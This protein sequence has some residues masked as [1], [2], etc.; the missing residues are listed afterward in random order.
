MKRLLLVAALAASC[1]AC[2][3]SKLVTNVR[4]YFDDSYTTFSN[5]SS[6][7]Y[8]LFGVTAAG[9]LTATCR[10]VV[11]GPYNYPV[12][13]PTYPNVVTINGEPFSCV[14]EFSTRFDVAATRLSPERNE[15]WLFFSCSDKR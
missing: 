10:N 1:S 7:D 14:Y 9:H 3:E 8:R 13:Y 15:E 6:P 11:T 4:L 12:S 2:A 5:C